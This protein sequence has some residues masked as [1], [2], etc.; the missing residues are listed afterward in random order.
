[1]SV[2]YNVYFYQV[3]KAPSLLKILKDN[4]KPLGDLLLQKQDL[5]P[6]QLYPSKI[7][8]T[9]LPVNLYCMPLSSVCSFY[10]GQIMYYKQASEDVIV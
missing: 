1:M 7:E 3:I 2:K 6:S 4:F 10:I 8:H 9:G 5:K